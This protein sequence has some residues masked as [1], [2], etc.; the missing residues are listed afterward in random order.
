M[1]P[2]AGGNRRFL[3]HIVANQRLQSPVLLVNQ[4][5]YHA[6]ASAMTSR[7]IVLAAS[8]AN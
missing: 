5:K 4:I 3:I 2:I 1:Q 6:N 8:R 7:R